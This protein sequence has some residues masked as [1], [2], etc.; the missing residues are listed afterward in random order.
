MD[1]LD[2]K[3]AKS[4]LQKL[5]EEEYFMKSE[6]FKIVTSNQTLDKLLAAL[7]EDGYVTKKLS[8]YGRRTY[9][10][11][12]TP[13]GRQVA[14]QLKKAQYAAEGISPPDVVLTPELSEKMKDMR[15]LIHV[16]VKDDHIT[17]L[18]KQP[19]GPDRVINI[20]VRENGKRGFFRL[21]CELDESFDCVHAQVAWT[22]PEV[23]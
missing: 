16:N 15:L 22:Y 1:S 4:V 18:E 11:S 17:V 2:L 6:L 9:T 3:Y 7:E 19:S 21:W 5:T 13:K 14:E 23:Q 20:Y 12:L 8:T 10:I